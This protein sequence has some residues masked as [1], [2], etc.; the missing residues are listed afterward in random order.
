LGLERDILHVAVAAMGTII[1]HLG[2]PEATQPVAET[3]M[4]QVS[5]VVVVYMHLL[6][7]MG[8]E[9]VLFNALDPAMQQVHLSI[10]Y[11]RY[12]FCLVIVKVYQ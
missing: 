11:S 2:E 12:D 5:L 7:A 9:A 3:Q 4:P 6:A 1:A 10:G 8:A